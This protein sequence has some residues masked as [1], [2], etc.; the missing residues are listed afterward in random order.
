MSSIPSKKTA[1]DLIEQ[2]NKALARVQE[3][4]KQSAAAHAAAERHQ[5][6][7][8]ELSRLPFSE[9]TLETIALSHGKLDALAPLSEAAEER[10]E[11]TKEDLRVLLNDTAGICGNLLHHYANERLEVIVGALAP[12]FR[13][14][15]NALSFAR[16]TDEHVVNWSAGCQFT[17]AGILSSSAI[18]VENLRRWASLVIDVLKEAISPKPDFS[19]FSQFR[20][21]AETTSA[22]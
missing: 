6:K 8:D 7:I 20:A 13:E 3:I 16:Q 18:S 1:Q 5:A 10:L 9:A 11:G 21:P 22:T 12:F 2:I 19:K 4:E 17:Q 14:R 15:E